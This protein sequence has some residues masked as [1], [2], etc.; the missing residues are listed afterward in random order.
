M[1]A[2]LE[3]TS[4]SDAHDTSCRSTAPLSREASSSTIG[5]SVLLLPYAQKHSIP[6]TYCWKNIST[7]LRRTFSTSFQG[8]TTKK[9]AVG[10]KLIKLI[11]KLARDNTRTIDASIPAAAR[12][13]SAPLPTGSFHV[14]LYR[15]SGRGPP[16]CNARDVT[17]YA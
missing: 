16:S 1:P 3:V 13:Q 5:Y 12:K 10:S 7:S 17:W 15:G 11:M 4:G 14:C 9:T 8:K 2:T 6:G